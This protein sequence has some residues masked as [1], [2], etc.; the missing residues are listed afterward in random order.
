MNYLMDTKWN[1]MPVK[2]IESK[3]IKGL[4]Q[5]K[6]VGMNKEQAIKLQKFINEM[7]RASRNI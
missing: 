7:L 3:A 5:V 2:A 6:S 4:Y 1:S